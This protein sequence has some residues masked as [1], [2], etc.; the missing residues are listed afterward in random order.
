MSDLIFRRMHVAGL[1]K[2]L[3]SVVLFMLVASLSAQ[4]LEPV[5][6]KSSTGTKNGHDYVDLGLSVNW[7]TANIGAKKSSDTG[8]YYAWGE[9]TT[10]LLWTSCE[11]PWEDVGGDKE[12]DAATA[13]W[14]APWRMPNSDEINELI[15]NCEWTWTTINGQQGYLAKSKKN[16]KEIFLPATGWMDSHGAISG[17]DTGCYWTSES[18][19]DEENLRALS[20]CFSES[21]YGP[22]GSWCGSW[23]YGRQPIR[24]VMPK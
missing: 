19:E 22:S 14:G 23:R 2:K 4:A 10:D 17:E 20:L 12:R 1:S 11:Q 5:T 13:N 16:G 6:S 18:A 24:P 8:D 3:L 15:D 9:V 21:D 7:A